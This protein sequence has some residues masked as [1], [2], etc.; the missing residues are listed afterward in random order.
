MHTIDGDAERR[1][2]P[3]DLGRSLGDRG[4]IVAGTAAAGS[5]L[6][7]TNSARAARGQAVRGPALG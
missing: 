6:A 4:C 1:K 5:M 3:L 2:R 7:R